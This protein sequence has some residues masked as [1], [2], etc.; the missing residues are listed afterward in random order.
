MEGDMTKERREDFIVE[1]FLDH[2][3][4]VKERPEVSKQ[5]APF[6]AVCLTFDYIININNG[7]IDLVSESFLRKFN[8][9][10]KFVD[11]NQ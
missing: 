2:L 6:V 11:E 10:K 7:N 9:L 1:T 8:R 4:S 3:E 5:L